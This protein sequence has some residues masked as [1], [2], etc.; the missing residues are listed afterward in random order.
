MTNPNISTDSNSSVLNS[1]GSHSLCTSESSVIVSNSQDS[2]ITFSGDDDL[3]DNVP[4]STGVSH[5]KRVAKKNPRSEIWQ[6][7]E[8]FTEDKYK[9]YAFC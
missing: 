4:S 1:S 2:G 5:R 9:S 6:Y 8:V 3:H 7:F